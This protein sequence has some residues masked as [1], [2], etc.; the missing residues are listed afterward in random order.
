M[1]DHAR[2][3]PSSM[4]R[5]ER[6]PGSLQMQEKHPG[7]A[8]TPESEEGTAAHWVMAEVLAGVIVEVGTE[9]PNGV[10]VTDEMLRGADMMLRS[11][12]DTLGADWQDSV[13]VE[14]RVVT[15]VLHPSEN[16][17]T[18]DVWAE[19]NGVLYVWDYKFGYGYVEVLRNR[20]LLNYAAL[21]RP[22]LQG[23]IVATIVQPRL[24]HTDGKVRRWDFYLEHQHEIL[25]AMR[26][27][28][29]EALG[30]LPRLVAGAAQQC[31]DCSARG[32]CPEILRPVGHAIDSSRR[33]YLFELSP[34]HIGYELRLLD[35]T[36]ALLQA[37][38]VGLEE[39]AKRM[40]SQ[41]QGVPGWTMARGQGKTVWMV[42]PARAIAAGA[43]LG[44]NIAKPAEAL[45]PLQAIGAG[46][47]EVVVKA[48]SQ[49]VP[50]EAKLQHDNADKAMSVFG[51]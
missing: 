4:D 16:W 47:D 24:H 33:D 15:P 6:C 3:A 2:A 30:P 46:M 7:P 19:R 48:M 51:D 25:E 38:R 41:G 34:G 18:P 27:A 32:V 20:Q 40:I 22:S 13:H 36:I 8:S 14:E 17:G 5:I 28:I 21:L 45:T 29:R 10:K 42:E 50:G 23:R 9:T 26:A 11:I 43:V 31:R 35:E 1:S 39:I 12:E 37:R 44:V 49:V